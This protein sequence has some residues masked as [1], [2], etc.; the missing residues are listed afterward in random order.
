MSKIFKLQGALRLQ[1]NT[2]VVL[3][4]ATDLKIKYT[5][6]SGTSSSWT[7]TISGTM[8]IYKDMVGTELDESGEWTFWAYVTFSDGRKAAGEAVRIMV[9]DEGN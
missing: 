6:P 3:T 1:L 5:K 4:T 2:G 8:S 9:Y 7:G